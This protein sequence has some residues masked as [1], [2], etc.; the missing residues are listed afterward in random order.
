M[1]YQ[2]KSVAPL[3]VLMVAAECKGLAKVGGLADVVRDLTAELRDQGVAVRLIV[4]GYEQIAATGKTVL[5]SRVAFA[6][7]TY[8]IAVE[9][10]NVDGFAADLVRCPE[11]FGGAIGA[12]YIDSGARGGGPFEDDAARFAFFSAAVAQLLLEEDRYRQVNVLHCHDWHTGTLALL[13]RLSPR[14]TALNQLATL[15]TI[16]NLDYQG[17]RPLRAPT[18]PSSASLAGWFPQDYAELSQ[19][20]NLGKLRDPQAADCYNPMRTAIE[21]AD[22]VSTVSPNY[23]REITRADDSS[24]SFIGG[25]GL[26]SLL[27]RRAKCGSLVGLLNGIDYREFDPARLTPPFSSRSPDWHE[28]KGRHKEKLRQRL[29]AADLSAAPDVSG[30]LLNLSAADSFARFPLLVAVTRLAEQK[31][32]LLFAQTGRGSVLDVLAT[33]PANILLL[34]TGE[35]GE[36]LHRN[37]RLN[38]RNILHVGRFDQGLADL[39]YSAGDLF[40]MPSDFEPCGISQ[41]IAMRYGTLPVVTPVGG[42]ADTVLD[43]INGYH[44][45]M[46]KGR[47]EVANAVVE[48]LRKAIVDYV[49][50]PAQFHGMQEKA[51]EARFTW[52]ESARE[53]TRLY[54]NIRRGPC[55]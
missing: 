29:L 2:S 33:L 41:M 14:F 49:S 4:P 16:H 3:H 24:R 13:A 9:E 8:A 48:S 25:R 46:G 17:Q 31:V 50:H 32:S 35:F 37:L 19:P 22:F 53:Y 11:F 30:A 10:V 1:D 40:L 45:P 28:A 52:K 6:G 26:E 51:M 43:G 39:L 5:T 18:A 15:F 21:L 23:A 12:V 34:G 44:V 38:P 27:S 20:S 54:Q 42:L 7:C 55:T 47:Q 36:R